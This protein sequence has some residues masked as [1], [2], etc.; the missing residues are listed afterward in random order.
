MK[1]VELRNINRKEGPLYY[2]RE[3]KADA[4]VEFMSRPSS[5]PIEFVIEHRAVG[6]CA[7]HVSML[8]DL[9][10]PLVPFVSTLKLYILE[11]DKL[12]AL[13]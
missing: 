4:I 12:G 8:E 11:L 3:Y 6:G 1:V 10:Y 9:E 13:P 5:K 2:R 7:V